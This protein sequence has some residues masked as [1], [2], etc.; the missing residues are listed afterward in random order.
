[1]RVRVRNPLV[2]L[3]LLEVADLHDAA[4]RLE[5]VQDRLHPDEALHA[6]DLLGQER[7]VVAELDV[8][9]ARDVAEA[10]VERHG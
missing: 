7:S 2:A 8:T 3:D 9:L 1:M 4:R 5:V 6:H 10:L